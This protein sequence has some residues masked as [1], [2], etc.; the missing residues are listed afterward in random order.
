VVDN[1][2]QC[3]QLYV[4]NSIRT[5][6]PNIEDLI[7]DFKNDLLSYPGLGCPLVYALAKFVRSLYALLFLKY[8]S[9]YGEYPII[10]DSDDKLEQI[11][12]HIALV[13]TEGGKKI[14]ERLEQNGIG[15]RSIVSGIPVSELTKRI[16]EDINTEKM[17]ILLRESYYQIADPI[18]AAIRRRPITSTVTNV[19]V[20]YI[21]VIVEF[22][23][24]REQAEKIIR[25]FELL[26]TQLS[27]LCTVNKDT[28]QL[29][30]YFYL[31]FAV[32]YYVSGDS[33][34]T[35]SVPW[36]FSYTA[37]VEDLCD[38]SDSQLRGT[39]EHFR[40]CKRL[41]GTRTLI[42][43]LYTNLY[44][45][46]PPYMY[47]LIVQ[48]MLNWHSRK[49]TGK[50]R[51]IKALHFPRNVFL[52]FAQFIG[53]GIITTDVLPRIEQIINESS[54]LSTV[55][56]TTLCTPEDVVRFELILK[57]IRYRMATYKRIPVYPIFEYAEKKFLR[58]DIVL[59]NLR[60]SLLKSTNPKHVYLSKARI[61]PL[62]IYMLLRL[63]S[64]KTTPQESS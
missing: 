32:P 15:I 11:A 31:H 57:A 46:M 20:D 55:S 41:P 39:R 21:P 24:T 30:E 59:A 5:H 25:L 34:D 18:V 45:Y 38:L 27:L 9:D 63:K 14:L 40:V 12:K 19:L 64:L 7:S 36:I 13:T 16:Q 62:L 8:K 3:E 54:D 51:Q 60:A 56:L 2:P 48:D 58:T 33:S 23:Y 6:L 29:L 47:P 44:L 43:R 28:L 61:S 42:E 22:V 35:V 1:L 17:H 52:K 10:L 37:F 50:C 49:I 4:E 26:F 53:S